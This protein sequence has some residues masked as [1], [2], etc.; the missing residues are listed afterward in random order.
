MNSEPRIAVDR[1]FKDCS[2]FA[3]FAGRITLSVEVRNAYWHRVEVRDGRVVAVTPVDSVPFPPVG[4][5]TI[6]PTVPQ[7]FERARRPREVTFLERQA[8]EGEAR[9]YRAGRRRSVASARLGIRAV[10]PKPGGTTS[11]TA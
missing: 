1:A 7:L 5:L 2:L 10:T 8:R 9:P 3:A 11:G 6:W 4:P